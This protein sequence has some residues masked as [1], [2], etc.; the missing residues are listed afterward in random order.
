VS[1]LYELD[2]DHFRATELTRGP[3]DQGSQHAGPPGALVGRAI[4]RVANPEGKFVGRVTLE[5]LRPIP[6]KTLSVFAEV[7]R[8]GRSVELVEAVLS[9]EDGDIIRARAWRLAERPLDAD[10][11]PT[12]RMPPPEQGAPKDF[13]PTGHDVGYHTATE[14]RFLEGEYN[15]PGPARV[16]MR[17]LQPLVEG[18][19][20]TPLQRVLAVADSGN[21]VSSPLDYDSYMFINT[22][23][24]VHLHR[25]PEGE[26]VGLDSISMVE[27][28]GVG[29]TDTA[30]FDRRGRIGR[31]V[32]TLLVRR[33]F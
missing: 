33:R 32:Q 15:E 16:W 9:D 23:L 25:H 1:P 22:D 30:L 14:H 4:E 13:F 7:V 6:I 29:M 5:I 31:A 18:E 20:A 19:E 11:T 21:G 27:P 24:T 3:W 2:G 26:W 8:P 12:D 28:E 17:V 10:A